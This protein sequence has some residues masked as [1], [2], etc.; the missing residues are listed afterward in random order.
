MRTLPPFQDAEA[1]QARLGLRLAAGLSERAAVLPHD[2]SERLRIARE[3]AL[4]RAREA[5]RPALQA[6][7]SFA[8]RSGG[9]ALLGAPPAW[10]QR[11]GAVVPLIVLVAGLVLIDQWQLS[12]QVQAAAE[13]DSVLLAD[14]LPPAAYSDPGFAEFLRSPQP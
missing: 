8:G 11:A 5:R 4:V 2:I 7:P 6:A 1:L 3:Q 13:I 10:W 14:D 12:E 9:A